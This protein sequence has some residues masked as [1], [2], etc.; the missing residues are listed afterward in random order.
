ME[1]LNSEN[2]QAVQLISLLIKKLRYSKLK[3]STLKALDK[4]L[5][6]LA[7]YLTINKN[8]ALVFSIIFGLQMDDTHNLEMT[9]VSCYLGV[10]FIELMAYK[11]DV[12]V[13]I[14]RG[15]I[16]TKGLNVNAA[17]PFKDLILSIDN[18]IISAIFTNSKIVEP[19]P[20]PEMDIWGFVR[21]TSDYIDLRSS[22]VIGVNELLRLVEKLELANAKLTMVRELA[23][24]NIDIEDRVL[25]YEMCDDFLRNGKTG[26]NSTLNNM[27]ER[28]DMRCRKMRELQ[29]QNNKLIS[30]DLIRIKEEHFISESE[31]ELTEKGQ[32]LFM[33]EN[34][35]LYMKKANNE[36]IAADKVASKLLFF[37]EKLDQQ[38]RFFQDSLRND[39]FV[40]MQDRLVQMALPKGIS[41]IFYGAPGT[42]KT[43]TAY[44]LAKATGRDIMH[45]DISQSKSMWFGES[46]K[47]IKEIFTRYATLC[48]SCELKP[49]LLFNEADAL[50]AKRKDGNASNLAQTENAIQNIIL[51]EMEKLEGILI[52]TT[53]LNQNLDAAFERRF[54]FKVKFEIPSPVAKQKI[55]QNKLP[56]LEE[57][58]AQRL[59][60]EFSFSGGEIDNVVRK[61]AMEEVL[62]GTKP[63]GEQIVQFCSNE[64]FSNNDSRRSLGF[65]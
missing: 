46:E 32:N 39:N 50:F 8:Q 34:A 2:I 64:K 40:N 20:E 49:I 21:K 17:V 35:S 16:R 29:N 30:Y 47:R 27:Y 23:L 9:D 31:L 24:L 11:A 60:T 62:T 48:K 28:I 45:V 43:E 1:T 37:D 3:H 53:N 65:R 6:S 52:A 25:F 19:Q 63:E 15:F 12:D 13:L 54:L 14:A 26:L 42:G 55:W 51:E 5:T 38:V 61:I 56:W 7:Q 4:E 33:A 36:L 22:E 10:N 44:Q 18:E 57:S 41:A 59:A 58:L